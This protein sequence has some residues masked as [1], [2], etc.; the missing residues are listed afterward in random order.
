M[1]HFLSNDQLEYK[2]IH[3]KLIIAIK[4]NRFLLQ[5][6]P[7]LERRKLLAGNRFGQILAVFFCR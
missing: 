7:Q 6:I 2:L 1:D 4:I 5:N 3:S